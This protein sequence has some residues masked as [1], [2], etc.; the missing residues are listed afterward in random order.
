MPEPVTPTPDAE[1]AL[2]HA[3]APLREHSNGLFGTLT[4][5]HL[6]VLVIFTSWAFGGQAPWVRDILLGWG[7]LG[8]ILFVSTCGDLARRGAAPFAALRPLWPLLVFDLLVGASCLNPSFRE[9]LRGGV[10]YFSI[11]TPPHAWLPSSARPGLSL[12]ELWQF[13]AIVLSCYNLC[14]ALANRRALRALLLL[15]AGNAVA[16]AVFGT[17]QKLAGSPGL[18]LGL[19]KSPNVHFFATFIYHNHWAAFTLLNLGVCLALLFHSLRRDDNRDR[20][21]SPALTGAT[22]TL[23]LAASVPLSAS[24]SGS[25]LAGLL[26]LAAFVHFLLRLVRRRR[27][28]NESAALP[29]T[30]LVVAAVLAVAAIGWLGRNVIAQ[31]AQ[32]T[33]E[34]L[35][36]IRV[37]DTLNSRLILY[38][39]T[40]RMAAEKIWFGWGLETY[41]HVFRIFNSQRTAERWVPFYAE[42]HSDWLQ[43]VAEVGLV[44]TALLVLL[45][46]LPL[47]AIPWRRVQSLVPRYLLGGCGLLLLYAWVEFPFA[48]P[49]VMMTFWICLYGAVR[50]ASLDLRTQNAPPA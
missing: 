41:A 50:Y 5:I 43:S 37:E 21:H 19:V 25:L 20:W 46:A 44:G 34:Q 3:G 26:L 8:M 11:Q 18:W 36:R 33:A 16:L 49:S 17:F 23:L 30:A 29:A 35:E 1:A 15:L 42:A 10:P 40:W 27:E 9:I 45:G 31:R 24:R 4:L 12:R 13:N 2:A 6:G 28:M 22:A 14:L 32:L 47:A 7:T 38:R 39:D 48:N